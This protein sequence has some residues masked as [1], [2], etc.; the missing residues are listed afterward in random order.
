MK[1]RI[2]TAKGVSRSGRVKHARLACLPIN[3]RRLQRE[4]DLEIREQNL[5]ASLAIFNAYEARTP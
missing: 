2:P 1:P 3:H 4:R 5:L